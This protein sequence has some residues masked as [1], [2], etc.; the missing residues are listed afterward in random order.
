MTSAL[1]IK[2]ATNDLDDFVGLM[3]KVIGEKSKSTKNSGFCVI[4]KN[5]KTGKLMLHAGMILG[6]DMRQITT[7]H[8][9]LEE[10][11][12]QAYAWANQMMQAYGAKHG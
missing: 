1:E 7:S 9:N 11:E 6:D 4:A 3:A 5:K 12:M 8:A 2:Q 10:C